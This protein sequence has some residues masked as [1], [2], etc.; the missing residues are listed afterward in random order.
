MRGL[1]SLQ[2]LLGRTSYPVAKR[3]RDQAQEDALQAAAGGASGPRTSPWKGAS[4][5]LRAQHAQQPHQ[6]H[7]QEQQQQQQHSAVKKPKIESFFA[8][9]GGDASAAGTSGQHAASSSSS[10]VS[11]STPSRP[12]S[13]AR[14]PGSE[15]A[16]RD[17]EYVVCFQTRIVGA[18]YQDV[19][20]G[21]AA[22]QQ[23]AHDLGQKQQEQQGQQQWQQQHAVLHAP[24]QQ[25]Q[26]GQQQHAVLRA[27]GQRQP[28]QGQLAQHAAINSTN[29][30][31]PES[32]CQAAGQDD[33]AFSSQDM[34][35]SPSL[36]C[37]DVPPSLPC[38]ALP[39]APACGGQPDTLDPHRAS[40]GGA[41]AQACPTAPP[42][43]I[44]MLVLQR[45]R[46][47]TNDANSILVSW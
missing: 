12:R 20:G 30:S 1:G 21:K 24:G 42:E 3:T 14:N 5:A 40:S 15:F 39:P 17:T 11:K 19:R 25:Q 45:E 33:E 4:A 26:Q 38:G 10:K 47:N 46:S 27:P 13:Q 18:R 41:G 6:E 29:H 8:S 16:A 44:G 35:A 31:S 9:V 32:P 7:R 2:Q 28:Q 43:P 36:P 34:A 37:G 23:D 22:L